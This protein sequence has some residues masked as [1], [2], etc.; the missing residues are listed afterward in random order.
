MASFAHKVHEMTKSA[1]PVLQEVPVLI[2]KH[3]R[4]RN[5]NVVVNNTVF[6]FGPDGIA[7]V[8]NLAGAP[9]AV[10]ALLKRYSQIS[11]VNDPSKTEEPVVVVTPIEPVVV[12]VK[13]E[14]APEPVVEDVIVVSV[15]PIQVTLPVDTYPINVPAETVSS[16]KVDVAVAVAEVEA[17]ESPKMQA[18]PVVEKPVRKPVAIKRPK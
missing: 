4:L 2:L 12:P 17:Q 1:T 7:K 11:W 15:E 5:R 6:S 16:V 3:S 10:T 18:A 9:E 8:K 13:L 14:V